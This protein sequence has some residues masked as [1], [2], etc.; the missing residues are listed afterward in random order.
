MTV[1]FDSFRCIKLNALF[2]CLLF[3]DIIIAPFDI[4]TSVKPQPNLKPLV[5]S[6]SVFQALIFLSLFISR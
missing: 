3:G 6:E 4:S 2:L 1:I 5:M